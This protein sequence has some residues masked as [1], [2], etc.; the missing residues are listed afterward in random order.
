[1]AWQPSDVTSLGNYLKGIDPDEIVKY[2]YCY[3]STLGGQEDAS[4]CIKISLDEPGEWNNKIFHNSNYAIFNV[5]D[6]MELLSKGPNMPKFRKCKV[7]NLMHIAE[8][9]IKYAANK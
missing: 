8:K 1:M 7:Q 4:L 2:F 3:R 5:G 6:K 9:L